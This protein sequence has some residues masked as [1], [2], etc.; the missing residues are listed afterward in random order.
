MKPGHRP[1]PQLGFQGFGE[2][3]DLLNS[4]SAAQGS[5]AADHGCRH[6]LTQ[7]QC[8]GTQCKLIGWST[9]RCHP[10]E[11]TWG[12][13]GSHLG[14]ELGSPFDGSHPR[15]FP[16]GDRPRLGR[17]GHMGSCCDRIMRTGSRRSELG[18]VGGRNVGFEWSG[19][20][21]LG[22]GG[23]LGAGM[24]SG[25]RPAQDVLQGSGIVVGHHTRQA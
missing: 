5:T 12:L 2:F 8:P 4:G 10:P 19:L 13:P 1:W 9:H 24:T 16:R 23:G 7:S 11:A 15:G 21:P 17:S 22:R 18:A 14:E 3:I 25:N 20:W 6:G